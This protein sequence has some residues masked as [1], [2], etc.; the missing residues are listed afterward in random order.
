MGV[1]SDTATVWA[2]FG[3]VFVSEVGLEVKSV[4]AVAVVVAH[5]LGIP[6]WNVAA[7]E[8]M[9]RIVLVLVQGV[10][11]HSPC[12]IVAIVALNGTTRSSMAVGSDDRSPTERQSD[13]LVSCALRQ[14]V[15]NKQHGDLFSSSFLP[16]GRVMNSL[17]REMDEIR[18]DLGRHDPLDG[19]LDSWKY[20]NFVCIPPVVEAGVLVMFEALSLF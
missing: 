8:V 9:F 10:G 3:K 11:G 7:R 6:L 19:D 2:K 5:M 1:E 16:P 18:Q 13:V 20:T 17:E 4:V 12:S 15:L 14:P